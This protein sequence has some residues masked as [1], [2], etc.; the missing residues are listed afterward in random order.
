MFTRA[1]C[2]FEEY[3][4]SLSEAHEDLATSASSRRKFEEEANRAA[5]RRRSEA[6][7]V[8]W[9]F[10]IALKRPGDAAYPPLRLADAP[11]D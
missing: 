9:P 1:S 8:N 11:G 4:P 2:L 10:D 6:D 5:T 7:D 3:A